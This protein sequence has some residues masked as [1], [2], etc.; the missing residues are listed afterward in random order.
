M[1]S[2]IPHQI[3][4]YSSAEQIHFGYKN[5]LYTWSRAQNY[6]HIWA[7]L[8][9]YW[10][11]PESCKLWARSANPERMLVLKTT[12]IIE[13]YSQ[14]VKREY[15]HRHSRTHFDLV[16]WVPFTRLALQVVERISACLNKNYWQA[17]AAWSKEFMK[18]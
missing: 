8:L 7:Y 3:G 11:A 17:K 18:L 15:F 12:M 13:S 9:N 2:S 5:E 14:I 6:F 10:H 16:C 4:L 1:L